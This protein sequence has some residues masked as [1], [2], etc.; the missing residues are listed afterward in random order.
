MKPK[1]LEKGDTIGL[2]SPASAQYNR[3]WITRSA[4]ALER[5]G[6]KVVLGK[7]AKKKNGFF[8]GTD[9]ERSSDL[10]EMFRREDIDAV[11]AID[12]GY[13]SA[14]LLRYLDF[15]A[16]RANPKIFLG[17]SDITILHLAINKLTGLT[18]FHGPGACSFPEEYLSPYTK[19][20]LEKALCSPEPVGEIPLADPKKY[21]HAIGRG[22]VE[23]PIIGGNMS[24]VCTTLGTPYEI[25]VKGK[26]LFLED[27]RLE[28]WYI[29]HNMA[30]LLNSGKLSEAVGIVI[31][32]CR[33]CQPKAHEPDYYSDTSI[34]DI[35]DEYLTPLGVPVL[36]GYPLGHTADIATLPMGV[37]V[38]VDADEKKF[39]V[40]ESGVET[41]VPK[42]SECAK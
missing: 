36:F 19:E 10:N 3:S 28:P 37:R 20:Q 41:P 31:G 21:I 14:R 39:S 11:M 35:F 24:M 8:A 6:Y 38:R 23:A 15:D 25:D 32:E 42:E 13:G 4:E 34:E 16:I 22:A 27:V 17:F 7:N 26:I 33:D 18:T 30:H 1:I 9:E 5:W 40:L 29:D 12:G 2:V